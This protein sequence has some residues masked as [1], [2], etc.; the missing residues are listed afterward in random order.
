LTVINDLP[1]LLQQLDNSTKQEYADIGIRLGIPSQAF[2][3]YA[4]FSDQHYT[5]NCIERTDHYELI[6]LCWE[7]GQGTP[8]HCH[9]GEECWVYILEG[10]LEEQHYQLNNQ[11]LELQSTERL[12][13]GQKSFMCD[14]LGFHLLQN[15]A[16]GRSM[17]LHLYMDPI[18][19]CS[20]FKKETNS[21]EKVDL[22]YYS[23]KGELAEVVVSSS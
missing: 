11:N 9:G 14:D 3:K 22:S 23:F 10:Q 1:T 4:H 2:A 19:Q 12:A 21:F 16:S 7:E 6:L 17:S 13:T 20:C 5:R 18:D 8:V 15:R